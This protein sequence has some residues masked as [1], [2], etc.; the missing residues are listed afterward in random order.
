[1]ASAQPLSLSPTTPIT[2]SPVARVAEAA[3][4]SIL[5]DGRVECELC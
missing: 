2:H 5:S 1:M 3:V 4:C